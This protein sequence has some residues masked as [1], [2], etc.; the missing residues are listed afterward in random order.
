MSFYV[1]FCLSS[2]NIPPEKQK[3]SRFSQK[4]KKMRIQSPDLSDS[5][6]QIVSIMLVNQQTAVILVQ[7]RSILSE[8]VVQAG[9]RVQKQANDNENK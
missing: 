7:S 6:L 1:L 8:R 5:L 3:S 4:N 2:D 9:R